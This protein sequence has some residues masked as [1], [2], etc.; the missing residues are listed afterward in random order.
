[1]I[2]YHRDFRYIACIVLAIILCSCS[3]SKELKTNTVK[4]ISSKDHLKSE[5]YS[6]AVVVFTG[7][8]LVTSKS[9][10][11]EYSALQATEI[12]S[13]LKITICSDTIKIQDFCNFKIHKE[14]YNLNDTKY[15]TYFLIMNECNVSKSDALCISNFNGTNEGCGTPYSELIQSKN[16]IIYFDNGY[17]FYFKIDSNKISDNYKTNKVSGII[18]DTR[19]E[20]N[21]NYTYLG[22]VQKTYKDFILRFPFGSMHIEE[23]L[24]LKDQ[25]DKINDIEYVYK[26]NSILEIKKNISVGKIHIIFKPISPDIT[27]VEYYLSFPFENSDYDG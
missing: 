25:F 23:N 16:K 9:Q 1:M 26:L 12:L 27:E 11:K 14:P 21:V 4:T 18:G 6:N 3:E 17:F 8:E 24:I 15:N 7:S 13:N 22:N 10:S 20:W 5:L 19:Q 2:Q